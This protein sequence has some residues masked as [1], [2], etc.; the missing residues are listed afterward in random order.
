MIRYFCAM[1]NRTGICQQIFIIKPSIKF[2]DNSSND[3]PRGQNDNHTFRKG[4]QDAPK[5]HF[6]TTA[7]QNNRDIACINFMFQNQ[8]NIRRK[9][10]TELLQKPMYLYALLRFGV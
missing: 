1:L 3:S 10:G 2:H 8:T 7:S 6:I 4:F 9:Y 5:Y